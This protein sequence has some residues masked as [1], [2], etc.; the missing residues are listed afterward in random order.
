V[1]GQVLVAPAAVC[2]LT[3]VE[4]LFFDHVDWSALWAVAPMVA[5]LGIFTVFFDFWEN[6]DS[7]S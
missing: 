7:E 2:L 5:S 4:A 1:L 6:D 3:G